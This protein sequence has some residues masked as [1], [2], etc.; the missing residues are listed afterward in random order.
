M[1]SY[2]Y[3]HSTCVILTVYLSIHHEMH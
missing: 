1:N 3:N 2:T